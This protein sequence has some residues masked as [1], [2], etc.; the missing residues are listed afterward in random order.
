ML[1]FIN[2]AII[3]LFIYQSYLSWRHPSK[4]KSSRRVLVGLANEAF[5]EWKR[6]L[7]KA[8]ASFGFDEEQSKVAHECLLRTFDDISSA[9]S[10]MNELDDVVQDITTHLVAAKD[11]DSA[12]DSL[13]KLAVKF[14]DI[15]IVQKHLEPFTDSVVDN[16]KDNMASAGCTNQTIER[17][18]ALVVNLGPFI[19]QNGMRSFAVKWVEILE[20]LADPENAENVIE[21]LG[22]LFSDADG[23]PFSATVEITVNEVKEPTSVEHPSVGEVRHQGA[24]NI[25]DQVSESIKSDNSHVNEETPTE[26]MLAPEAN[27]GVTVVKEDVNASDLKNFTETHKKRARKI[28]NRYDLVSHFM[29]KSTCNYLAMILLSVYSAG[30]K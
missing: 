20:L 5:D 4:L 24:F 10:L 29:N 15:S 28:F 3:I 30:W 17:A 13:L 7:P 16:F 12:V 6:I 18:E 11:A 9:M 22:E 25:D 27:Q 23:L 14:C 8:C 19:V 2:A 1:L 21:S 26:D